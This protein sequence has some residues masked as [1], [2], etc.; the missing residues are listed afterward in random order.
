MLNY[1]NTLVIVAYRTN[2]EGLTKLDGEEP[3][4]SHVRPPVAQIPIIAVVITLRGPMV[5]RH[6]LCS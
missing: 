3:A 5:V 6:F 4:V 2:I 1:K